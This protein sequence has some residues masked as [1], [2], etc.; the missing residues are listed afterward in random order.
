MK[1]N[2]GSQLILI[3]GLFVDHM[4]QEL[5]LF[6]FRELIG[7]KFDCAEAIEKT[8]LNKICNLGP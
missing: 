8:S 1:Q 6:T 2:I 3:C 4:L 7:K 5:R